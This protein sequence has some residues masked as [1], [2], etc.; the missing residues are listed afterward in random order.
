MRERRQWG[1]NLWHIYKDMYCIITVTVCNYMIVAVSLR[2]LYL[3]NTERKHT[4]TPE[5]FGQWEA[6]LSDLFKWTPCWDA[7]AISNT[8]PLIIPTGSV[9]VPGESWRQLV[10]VLPRS[11]NRN[12]FLLPFAV[13]TNDL[14]SR[15]IWNFLNCVQGLWMGTLMNARVVEWMKETDRWMGGQWVERE[16][17]GKGLGHWRDHEEANPVTWIRTERV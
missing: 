13:S 14:L 4:F 10:A 11:L 5:E 17:E 9:W 1:R 16:R 7:A 8:A 2:Q 6:D 12:R 3:S 15:L